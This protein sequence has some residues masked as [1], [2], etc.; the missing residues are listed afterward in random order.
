MLTAGAG[1]A[2]NFDITGVTSIPDNMFRASRVQ[3]AVL[4]SGVTSIGVSAFN[5]CTG[6]TSV[7]IPDSVTSIGGYAFYGCTGL[8]SVTIPDSVT[9]I[10][11]YTFGGCTKLQ[12]VN[13][14]GVNSISGGSSGRGAFYNCSSI[15]NATFGKVNS[16][17]N[18]I[19]TYSF[20]GCTNTS[21]V[22]TV[23]LAEQNID[24][25]VANIRNGL[26][27]GTI[28]VKAANDL[29]YGGVSYSAG[30]TVLT[31]TP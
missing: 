15:A 16:P 5:G 8:T 23:Y 11:E 4:P 17:V 27:R 14:S 26:T 9:S 3:T 22:I 29:V 31:S 30:D 10:S 18:T 21:T 12:T 25:L 28:V 7:T 6:L 19:Q 20:Q 1:N 13:A 2:Y 24:T